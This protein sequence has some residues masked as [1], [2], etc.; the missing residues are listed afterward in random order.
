M[1]TL[2]ELY[3]KVVDIINNH[4][5]Y[6]CTWCVINRSE[7]WYEDS[8]SFDVHGWSDQGYGSEWTEYWSIYSDGRIFR[9][10]EIYKNFEE[11][12]GDWT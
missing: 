2:E 5:D 6:H 12:K 4:N 10:G 7:T 1:N 8:V 3:G 9:D 11:F